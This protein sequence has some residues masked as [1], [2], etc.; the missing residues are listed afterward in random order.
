[1]KNYRE[2]FSIWSC[3]NCEKVSVHFRW[4]E[5]D[6]KYD[7]VWVCADSDGEVSG[8]TGIC[9]DYQPD[10]EMSDLRDMI[11]ITER[12]IKWR[13]DEDRPAS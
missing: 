13:E 4:K 11:T 6:Q 10:Y 2:F 12:K 8:L 9:D 5:S 7:M 1:M 3:M